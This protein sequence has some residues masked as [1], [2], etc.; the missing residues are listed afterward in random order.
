MVANDFETV[1]S[2]VKLITSRGEVDYSQNYI[3]LALSSE[4]IRAYVHQIK[5]KIVPTCEYRNEWNWNV[6]KL[7]AVSAAFSTFLLLWII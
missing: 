5:R 4:E 6:E 1:D 2:E 7:A 3:D